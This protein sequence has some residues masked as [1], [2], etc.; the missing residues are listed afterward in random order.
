MFMLFMFY[1]IIS[2][3]VYF[4]CNMLNINSRIKVGLIG[5]GFIGIALKTWLDNFNKLVD[6]YI[7]DPAKGFN[8]NLNDCDAYFIQIHLPTEED[9]NQNISILIDIVNKLP[10]NVP[11]WI[12]TTILPGT[13]K[14]ISNKTGRIVYHMPEFLTQRTSIEDFKNQTMIFTGSDEHIE[15]LK[16]IFPGK[17]Y[18]VLTSEEAE[19]AKYAHNVFGALK[20]T[21]FNCVYD[22]CKIK[23]LN[24]NNV[25]K[26]ILNST[27]INNIHTY[28]PG[29]DGQL[30][31]GGKCF[32]KDVKA[33]L[34]AFKQTSIGK[35]INPILALN[36]KFRYKN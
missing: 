20:V 14:N 26:G 18:I 28:V 8:D 15:L 27:Y 31:F 11:I 21:Y 24:Y 29:P 36:E 32:P 25:L 9:G 33:F 23:N 35:L 34:T 16:R 12:R 17:Q 6:I 22:L 10:L 30:G 7:C 1:D 4:K 2:N 3:M 5:Y 19:L 13:S